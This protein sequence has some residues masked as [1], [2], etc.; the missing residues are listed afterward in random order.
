VSDDVIMSRFR[1][2]AEVYYMKMREAPKRNFPFF[3]EVMEIIERIAVLFMCNCCA[4][5]AQ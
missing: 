1:C 3:E 5:A 2:G 4:I